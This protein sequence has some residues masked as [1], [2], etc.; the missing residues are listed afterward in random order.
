MSYRP[1][2]KRMC[3]AKNDEF[4]FLTNDFTFN[5]KGKKYT[6]PY[7]HYQFI[8]DKFLSIVLQHYRY[9]LESPF[10]FLVEEQKIFEQKKIKKQFEEFVLSNVKFRKCLK[11]G[12][13]FLSISSSH[14][15]CDY[16]VK[17]Y[18]KGRYCCFKM[19]GERTL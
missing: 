17:G 10:E 6:I 14:R 8:F 19:W 1:D 12:N 16:C 18:K 3:L 9:T 4:A 7:L 13:E 15:R 2:S 11:C 5:C